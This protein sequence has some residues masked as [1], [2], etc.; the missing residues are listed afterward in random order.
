MQD[1][2]QEGEGSVEEV[3][4][5]PDGGQ[6]VEVEAFLEVLVWGQGLTYEADRG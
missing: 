1:D 4:N 2:A 3:D 5:V 6:L